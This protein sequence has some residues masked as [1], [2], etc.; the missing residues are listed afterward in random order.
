MLISRDA[1]NNHKAE[2]FERLLLLLKRFNNNDLSISSQLF[3]KFCDILDFVSTK[4]TVLN[5]KNIASILANDKRTEE[6]II[7][8]LELSF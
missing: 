8:H 4:L 5:Y 7:K 6:K 1:F 2:L 3:Y